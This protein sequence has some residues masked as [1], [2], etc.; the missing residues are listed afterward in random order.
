MF[1]LDAGDEFDLVVQTARQF[2]DDALVPAM[3][4]AERAREPDSG[5]R[6]TWNEIGLAALELPEAHDGAELGCLARALVNEELAAGDVGATLALDTF[7]PA[8]TALL[9]VGGN[10]ALAAGLAACD[11]GA[12]RLLLISGDDADCGIE[13]DGGGER[14]SITAPYVHAEAAGA[15]VVLLDDR[16]LLVESGFDFEP[17]RGAGL[18]ASG[19]ASLRADAAPIAGNWENAE[20]ASRARARARLYYASLLLGVMRSA[21]DFSAEYSQQREAFGRPIG[22]H[23]ALAFMITDMRMALEAARLVVHEAAWRV[24]RGLP[25]AS[26]AASAFAECIEVSRMVGPNGVQ[27]LGG[28]GFMA[29]YPVEKHMREARAL[30]LLCGG[31]DAA[32]DEAGRTLVEQTTPL[33]LGASGAL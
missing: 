20:G 29:D 31:F 4:D 16:A 3:R 23:Q 1:D 14:L 7:G 13:N 25:C 9:E 19:G 21:C 32:I 22:H 24:D 5:L 11:R 2:A 6:A 18:R 28:H 10:D 17:V 26:E 15:L 12:S 33:A 27:I 30:G 8:A